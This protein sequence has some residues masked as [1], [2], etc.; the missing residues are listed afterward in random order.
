MNCVLNSS[1]FYWY[2]STLADCE[3]INDGL[4][5]RFPLPVNWGATDWAVL[6]TAVDDALRQS[7]VPKMI[8]TK[9]GHII[10]YDEI[11]GKQASTVIAKADAALAKAFG[12]TGN[13]ADYVQN[14]DTK[15]RMMLG[16]VGSDTDA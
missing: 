12:L 9:Q 15:Y 8:N 11:N 13:E 6:S 1:L 3:H 2:Y 4:V 14:Y 16:V 7:A 5:R 10:E